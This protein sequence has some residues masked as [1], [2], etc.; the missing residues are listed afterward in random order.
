[1]KGRF[2]FNKK[3]KNEDKNE[4]GGGEPKLESSTGSDADTSVAIPG[5]QKP[6]PGVGITDLFR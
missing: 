5:P 1:M 4:L 6:L 2:F 3:G